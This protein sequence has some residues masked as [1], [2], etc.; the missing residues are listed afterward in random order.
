MRRGTAAGHIVEADTLEELAEKMDV[1]VE[2]FVATVKRY[3]ANVAKGH[4]DDFGKR[5]ELLMGIDKPPY[6]GLKFG[7][8][9]LAVV[10]GLKVGTRMDV[11]DGENEPIE[12]LYAIGNAAGGRYGVDYPMLLPGNSHGTALTFGYILG[13]ILADKALP[14]M[15]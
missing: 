8:A 4:D 7:P 10:G 11:L 5:P 1:P 6:Y 14:E 2:E 13:D 9:L 12:G 15:R 3:N